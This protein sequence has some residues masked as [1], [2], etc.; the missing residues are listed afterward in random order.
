V[1]TRR[2]FTAWAAPAIAGVTASVTAAAP[3]SA[4]SAPAEPYEAAVAR[5][6]R[7]QQLPGLQG[8]ALQHE[9]VRCATLAASSHNTQCWTFALDGAGITILP[10]LSRRC[11]A[12]DPDDHHL[13]TSLGCA[14]E[15]LVQAAAA[16]GL[17]ADVA[18]DA[19]RSA[20]R[21]AL[22]PAAVQ[23]SPLFA[24]IAQRQCTRS[25]YDGRP[26]ASDALA[27]LEHAG[28][29][30]RVQLLLLTDRSKMAQVLELIV[31]G[32]TLQ[33]NDPAFAAELKHWIRF[34]AAD[35]VRTGDGLYSAASGNPSL[36]TW[37]GKPLFNFFFTAKAEN[38]R[39]ARQMRSSAGVAVFASAADDPA[40]SKATW[41]EVGRAYQRFALQATVLG[42]RHAFLNQPVEVAALRPQLAALLGLQG[43]RPDLVLRFG[44]GPAMP[45]SLRRPVQAVLV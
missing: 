36:P 1:T 34:S 38:D 44:H 23:A 24:A 2:Q 26:L 27:R 31:Q 10:D 20:V 41:I 43:L 5:I 25:E 35:A 7:A 40:T 28:R 12:A 16:Y 32:N 4:C 30:D 19:A 45:R 15:N 17:E 42:V 22:R 33:V 21:I 29:T 14:A 6:W 39:I 8:Q 9:L 11:P 3:L 37:L 13:F 18:F